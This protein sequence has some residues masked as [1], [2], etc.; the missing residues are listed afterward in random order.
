MHCEQILEFSMMIL[1]V[2]IRK[3]NIKERT[4]LV[5]NESVQLDG[6]PFSLVC[7][8]CVICECIINLAPG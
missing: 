8:M 4:H 7:G 1:S 6:C 2:S 3:I 5:Q